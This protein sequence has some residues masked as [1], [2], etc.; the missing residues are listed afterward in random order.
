[1]RVKELLGKEVLDANAKVVG[2]V[3]DV[4]LDIDQ[5]AVVNIVVKK[6]LIKKIISSTWRY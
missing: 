3:A 6:G 4:N 5:V 2:K 1:M